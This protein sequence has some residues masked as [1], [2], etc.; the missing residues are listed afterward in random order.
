MIVCAGLGAPSSFPYV[1]GPIGFM[2]S[3]RCFWGRTWHQ[4][5]RRQIS[6]L[7]LWPRGR[8]AVASPG[9]LGSAYI[10]L[11]TGF[12]VGGAT[13]AIAGWMAGNRIG[14]RDPTGAAVFFSLQLLG[15]M[16]EDA[17]FETLLA[18]GA[19][20]NDWRRGH[21]NDGKEKYGTMDGR[22]RLDSPP[23]ASRYFLI[24]VWLSMT[25]P[26]YV[27]GLRKVGILESRLV[28]FSIVDWVMKGGDYHPFS[29]GEGRQSRLQG[30]DSPG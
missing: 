9:S 5:A 7:G 17:V 13:H 18:T 27:E 15:V 14:W 21:M 12:A 23:R 4:A 22:W 2:D 30:Q 20:Q 1:M 8:M 11:C 25:M 29:I 16:L 24:V 26:A 6:S 10:Q 3:L 19:V 28:P